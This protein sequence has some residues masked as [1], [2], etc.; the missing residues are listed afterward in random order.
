MSSYYLHVDVLVLEENRQ[1]FEAAVSSFLKAGGFGRVDPAYESMA[2]L[3]ALISPE[4]FPFDSSGLRS[5]GTSPNATEYISPRSSCSMLVYRYVNVWSLPVLD[6]HPLMEACKDDQGP[7]GYVAI[8]SLVL[9]ETQELVGHINQPTLV[10]INQVG[11]SGQVPKIVRAIRQMS[12][13]NYAVYQNSVLNWFSTPI[14]GWRNLD[15]LL[16]VTSS[17]SRVAEFWQVSKGD[18]KLCTFLDAARALP[19][20]GKPIL[21]TTQ[22]FVEL[23]ETLPNEETRSIFDLACY[24][25][26]ILAGANA[27]SRT[28]RAKEAA[29]VREWPGR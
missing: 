26:S 14:P 24:D 23:Y 2:L 21:D 7:G 3:L 17:L 1:A 13:Y 4:P 12:A 18:Q 28:A 27:R 10:G 29:R 20:F 9:L 11:A 22:S 8:N 6:L 15:T 25:P 5:L 19:V 16:A